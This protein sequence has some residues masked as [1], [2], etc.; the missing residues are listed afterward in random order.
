M[1]EF[2]SPENLILIAVTA[3]WSIVLIIHSF[4]EL[5]RRRNAFAQNLMLKRIVGHKPTKRPL[6]KWAMVFVAFALMGIALLRPL[7]EMTEETIQGTGLDLVVALD[8][9]KSMNANDIDGNTR[10]DVAKAI[11]ANM[12][13]GLKRDRIGLVVFAGE[14]MV[15]S[16]LSY[17]KA[18]F[19]TFLNRVNPNLLSKQGTDLAGA[20]RTSIDRFDMNASQTKVIV[21][22]SDG[23]DQN[24]KELDMAIDEAEKKHIQIFTVGI[25]SKEGGRIPESRDPFWGTVRY[26]TYK[27]QVVVTKLN[28]KVLK[29]IAKRTNP[30]KSE[31]SYFRAYNVSSARDVISRI[32][33]LKR[34]AVSGATRM[35]KSELFYTPVLLAFFLLLIEWVISEHIPYEREKDHWLKRL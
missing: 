25:G 23:E 26:K 7:G 10:L 17:D 24:K 35:V 30:K 9:S 21:L 8:I 2:K 20:I 1:L 18:A 4:S 6:A 31:D 29:K 5:K 15:Q 22:I 28:D 12:I 3:V 33:K 19:L 27:G 11:L 34:I 16:P 13:Q 32:G 14:T